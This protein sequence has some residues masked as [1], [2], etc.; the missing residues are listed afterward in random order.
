MEHG[1]RKRNEAEDNILLGHD[2][3]M[4]AK[5][6][7]EKVQILGENLKDTSLCTVRKIDDLYKR[8]PLRPWMRNLAAGIS[9]VALA[10]LFWRVA[11]AYTCLTRDI[12]DVQQQQTVAS[13]ERDELV[14]SNNQTRDA[15]IWNNAS[16]SILLQSS[17]L[18]L[19]GKEDIARSAKL[20][21]LKPEPTAKESG[22][23]FG[24]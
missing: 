17:G 7:D 13:E 9:V 18:Q 21:G 22:A 11:V 12:D 10:L 5:S 8:L 14:I 3:F 19:P 1:D 16:L 20:L 23:H 24:P 6:T 15:L 2:R 4:R